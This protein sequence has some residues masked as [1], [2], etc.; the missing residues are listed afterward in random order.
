M[1][2]QNQWKLEVKVH[3]AAWKKNVEHEVVWL[4]WGS[5][6]NIPLPRNSTTR[7]LVSDGVTAFTILRGKERK[8]FLQ[9]A[10]YDPDAVWEPEQ[11]VSQEASNETKNDGS[12]STSL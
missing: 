4:D 12:T 7:L 10:G 8:K 11:E 9:D 6:H 3:G 1:S 2:E 5:F